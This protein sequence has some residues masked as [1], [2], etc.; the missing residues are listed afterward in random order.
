[1]LALTGRGSFE[2]EL[3]I[4][5]YGS[6]IGDLSNTESCLSDHRFKVGQFVKYSY[7]VGGLRRQPSGSGGIYKIT[8]LLPAEGDERLY[9]VKARMSRTNVLSRRPNSNAL[10]DSYVISLPPMCSTWSAKSRHWR[11]KSVNCALTPRS[12]ERFAFR[13]H[14]SACARNRSARDCCDAMEFPRELQKLRRW[15]FVPCRA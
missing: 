15:V 9:R 5:W 3:R 7:S 8:Q 11:A 13:S 4:S 10:S 6:V 12:L 2:C 1:M 14:S